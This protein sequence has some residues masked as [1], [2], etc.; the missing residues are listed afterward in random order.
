MIPTVQTSTVNPNIPSLSVYYNGN[1]YSELGVDKNIIDGTYRLSTA[2]PNQ[3]FSIMDYGNKSGNYQSSTGVV[4][5]VDVSGSRAISMDSD[6]NT[7]FINNDQINLEAENTAGL[8]IQAENTVDQIITN[9]STGGITGND[10]SQAAFI[11]TPEQTS[12]HNSTFLNYGVVSMNGINSS[13]FVMNGVAGRTYKITTINDGIVNL[14]GG[15]SYGMALSKDSNLA[16]GSELLNDSSGII[17][18]NSSNSGGISIQSMLSTSTLNSGIINI[19]V[20]N[21]LE[22]IQK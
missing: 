4:M 6:Y 12:T 13:G 5:V 21:L 1:G 15:N 22:F 19:T 18:V 8:E 14:N 9:S 11:F 2:V 20:R 17:N 10:D 7:T 16:S 3:Q